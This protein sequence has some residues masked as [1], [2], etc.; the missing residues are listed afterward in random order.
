ML[1]SV[2]LPHNWLSDQ[3]LTLSDA[4]LVLLAVLL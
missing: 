4:V 1:E 2:C 3:F